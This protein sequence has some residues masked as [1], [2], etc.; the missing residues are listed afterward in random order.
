VGIWFLWYPSI[1]GI[2][3]KIQNQ[4]TT[5]SGYLNIFRIKQHL[6]CLGIWKNSDSKNNQF[7]V[8]QKV[9]ST[10]GRLHERTSK[11]PAVLKAIIW[12]PW[13]F[14]RSEDSMV[15][16]N[17]RVSD[18]LNKNGYIKSGYL[19]F[20]KAVIKFDNR[21]DTRIIVAISTTRRRCGP[22]AL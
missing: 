4:R 9:Q 1:S 2:W 15:I 12:L 16:C 19:T 10:V 7:W 17:N 5:S 22:Y 3:K 13:L 8:F 6:P 20:L 11:D 18:F 21:N 14:S